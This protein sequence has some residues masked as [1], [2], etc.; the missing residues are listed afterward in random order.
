M[1]SVV[2]FAGAHLGG[3][4]RGRLEHV[5]LRQP[6]A[7]LLEGDDHFGC[8]LIVLKQAFLGSF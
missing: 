1:P 3:P 4:C 2:F 6:A 8:I 7:D 5:V